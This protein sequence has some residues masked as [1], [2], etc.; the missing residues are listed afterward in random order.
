[1]HLLP[2]RASDPCTPG[3]IAK[4]DVD[5]SVL[6]TGQ[7]TPVDVADDGTFTVEVT[8]EVGGTGLIVVA[9]TSGATDPAG[10]ELCAG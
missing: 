6:D 3:P 1:V 2:G 4:A 8:D 10:F 9:A 7:V 5:T